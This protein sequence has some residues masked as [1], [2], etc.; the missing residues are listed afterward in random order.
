[1]AVVVD[2]ASKGLAAVVLDIHHCGSESEAREAE[3]AEM[4]ARDRAG[5]TRRLLLPALA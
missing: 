1:V 4:N 2:F 5:M 3:V